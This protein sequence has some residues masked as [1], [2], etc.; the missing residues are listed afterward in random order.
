MS[1]EMRAF[2]LLLL[3]V[4]V[5]VLTGGDAARFQQ[6]KNPKIVHLYH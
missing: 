2:P 4:S 5:R 6:Q 1:K 3:A